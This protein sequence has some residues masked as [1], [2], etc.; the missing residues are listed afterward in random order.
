MN[1]NCSFYCT[2]VSY[3]LLSI[4]T[5][6]KN[7]SIDMKFYGKDV[8]HFKKFVYNRE[9]DV[10]IFNYGCLV[11]WGAEVEDIEQDISTLSE[12][13]S[14][15]LKRPISDRCEYKFVDYSENSFIEMS[16]DVIMIG[17]DDDIQLTKLS[18]S[19]GLSQSVKLSVFEESVDRTIEENQS[20]PQDLIKTGQISM[21]K[22]DLA[23][24]IGLLFTERNH[25][26][27]NNNILDTPEFFWKHPKYEQYY[28]MSLKFLDL[29]QRIHVL[30]TKLDIIRDLYSILSDELKY[31][32][33]SRLEIIVILLISI[34]V[35]ISI[36]ELMIELILK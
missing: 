31:S 24:K 13:V 33:S 21:S 5:H 17:N 3:D 11:F 15:S 25:I 34:E 9:Y 26:N 20:I 4:A 10:F 16:E 6:L 2:C 35:C 7:S 29:T 32:H 1:L 19:Y 30:N 36:F 14:E 27:L 22:K 12:F 18:F 23:K 8:L 28:E